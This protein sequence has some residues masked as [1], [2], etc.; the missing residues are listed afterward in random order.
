MGFV[1]LQCTINQIHVQT[2]VGRKYYTKYLLSTCPTRYGSGQL[3]AAT[4]SPLAS[5][6]RLGNTYQCNA[7]LEAWKCNQAK[8]LYRYVF[9]M[10]SYLHN[11][12]YCS[13]Q[14]VEEVVKATRE[15]IKEVINMVCYQC[16]E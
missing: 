6:D 5:E 4:M 16:Q 7:S 2:I 15:I 8:K 13:D 14:V 3:D 1:Q 11:S 9:Q 12:L 10:N